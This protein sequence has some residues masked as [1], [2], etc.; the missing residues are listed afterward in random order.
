MKLVQWHNGTY[1]VIKG[2]FMKTAVGDDG[3]WWFSREY[4]PKY[5]EFQT[6]EAAL[7][8]AGKLPYKV[9]KRV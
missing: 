3:Y 6:Q 8:A 1:G 2:I 9:I 5:C 4:W 7:R